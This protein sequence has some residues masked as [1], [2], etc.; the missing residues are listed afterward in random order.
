MVALKTLHFLPNVDEI[1]L[2]IVIIP[3]DRVTCQYS[4]QSKVK[5]NYLNGHSLDTEGTLVKREI[6]S[7]QGK[8]TH[9]RAYK[10]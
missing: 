7:M 6:Q 3:E 4:A 2:S 9:S 10:F 1:G 8:V 5:M